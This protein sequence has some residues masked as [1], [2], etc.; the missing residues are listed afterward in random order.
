MGRFANFDPNQAQDYNNLNVQVIFINV[1]VS[2]EN[3]IA[4][5][6]L[7]FLR[8]RAHGKKPWETYVQRYGGARE[9]RSLQRRMAC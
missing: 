3:E 8:V 2:L 5:W 6:S 4:T 7:R 9:R 1:N